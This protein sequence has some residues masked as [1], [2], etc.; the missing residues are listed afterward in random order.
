MLVP[1]PELLDN[2]WSRLQNLHLEKAAGRPAE[3]ALPIALVG[4]RRLRSA[5]PFTAAGASETDLFATE[6]EPSTKAGRESRTR[7]TD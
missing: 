2:R 1:T 5:G 4:A 3:P 6:F 7:A